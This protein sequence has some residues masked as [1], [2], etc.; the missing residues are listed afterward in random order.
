VA[1][2]V[3]VGV[4][5]D[6]RGETVLSVVTL[7]TG[8]TLS[9]PELQAFLRDK[10]SPVEMPKKLEILDAIPKTENAKLSR[11]AIRAMFGQ[12]GKAPA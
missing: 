6:Y 10:L 3:A 7:R 8:A 12:A 2:T 1:E 11:Q 4:P 9:L 5:D